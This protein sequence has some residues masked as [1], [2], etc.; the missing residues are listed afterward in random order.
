MG[1][2]GTT[3]Q[4]SNSHHQDYS[5]FSRESQPKPSF[6]TVTGWGVDQRFNKQQWHETPTNL[7]KIMSKKELNRYQFRHTWSW[8]KM[9]ETFE[10]LQYTYEFTNGIDR[11]RGKTTKLELHLWIWQVKR[12]C[13]LT[14][15]GVARSLIEYETVILWGTSNVW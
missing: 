13:C 5:L 6:M 9:A 8:M 7:D 12:F 14:F 2:L 11:N 1:L 15:P 3:P 4:P 10:P